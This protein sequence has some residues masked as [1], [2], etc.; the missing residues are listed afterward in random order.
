MER[1][2]LNLKLADKI[3][4]KTVKTKLKCN[5]NI[6]QALRRLK[7]DWAGHTAK[8]NDERWSYKLTVW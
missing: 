8:R 2:I 3:S 5:N 7:W 6:I 1:S 4:I